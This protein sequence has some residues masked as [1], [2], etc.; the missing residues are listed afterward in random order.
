LKTPPGVV[1]PSLQTRAMRAKLA[2]TFERR[3][4]SPLHGSVWVAHRRKNMENAQSG[5]VNL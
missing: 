4:V 1:V 2:N 3:A 5:Q